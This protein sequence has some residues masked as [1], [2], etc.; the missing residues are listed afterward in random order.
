M[1][2]SGWSFAGV[3]PYFKQHED[4]FLGAGAIHA[5]G[6]ELRIEQQ[7]YPRPWT[8]SLFVSELALRSTCV[9]GQWAEPDP[10]G[11]QHYLVVHGTARITAETFSGD[12]T[13]TSVG[14]R[15]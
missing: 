7:V 8:H 5:V 2:C 3:L 11:M 12:I 10:S 9:D 15:R 13:L 1:G 14:R 6:G 4:H